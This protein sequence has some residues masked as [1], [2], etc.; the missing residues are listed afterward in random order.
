VTTA[1]GQAVV[2]VLAIESHG[3]VTRTRL[4]ILDGS[5]PSEPLAPAGLYLRDRWEEVLQLHRL[6]GES[7]DTLEYTTFDREGTLP[8]PGD[9]LI[10]QCW[11]MPSQLELVRDTTLAWTRDRVP[12]ELDDEHCALTWTGIP[13]GAEAYRS[14]TGEWITVAAFETLIEG[15]LL[16]VRAGG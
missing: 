1:P 14:A 8:S 2:E 10:L 11:F 6:D 15:D 13:P 12:G 9:R 3:D 5:K 4:R 7:G 16:R